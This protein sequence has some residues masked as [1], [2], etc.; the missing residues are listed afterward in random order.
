MLGDRLL[1]SV[2]GGS[3]GERVGFL[4]FWRDLEGDCYI[5]KV[6]INII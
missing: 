1:K 5:K 2:L 4:V 3:W 6:Y